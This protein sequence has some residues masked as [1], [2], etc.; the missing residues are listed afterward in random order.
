LIRRCGDIEYNHAVVESA[1]KRKN[2]E[3]SRQSSVCTVRMISGNAARIFLI[4]AGVIFSSAGCDRLTTKREVQSVKQAETKASEG[5][6]L[7]AI[8]LYESALDGSSHSADIH[9]RLALL[10]DDKMNEPLHALH[11]FKRFLTL[12]PASPRAA[13]VKNF[14][15]RDE[16]SLLT[17]LSGDSM[18]SRAEAVRLKNENLSLR[19][20]I[21]D[22]WAHAK[23]ATAAKSGSHEGAK[24]SA[25]KTSAAGK[26][27]GHGRSYV[28]QSGDT[29]A[30]IA[31][32]FYKNSARW[33]K[34]LEANKDTLPSASKLKPGQTL[35]IP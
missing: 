8:S 10:Y 26:T 31:R 11:H 9:Y 35:V 25:E 15:K 2:I 4:A 20:E 24:A 7:E 16:I 18:V 3:A 22:K 29:L 27:E 28:V 14:M 30:S 23:E 1:A 6:Y 34:I 32:K 19:K 17:S 21:E 12:A 33:K 5:N 13:E